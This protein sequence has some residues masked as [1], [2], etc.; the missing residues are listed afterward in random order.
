MAQHTQL[1]GQQWV[2]PERV[3]EFVDCFHKKMD[4]AMIGGYK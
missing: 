4:R 2:N 3:K 1:Y